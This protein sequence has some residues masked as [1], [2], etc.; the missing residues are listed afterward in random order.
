[1][2]TYKNCFELVKEVRQGI[3]EYDDALASGDVGEGVLER[4]G[5][6]VHAGVAVAGLL[7]VGQGARAV[8]RARPQRDLVKFYDGFLLVHVG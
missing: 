5:H 8:A 6:A 7:Q 2:P 4:R 3:N 1:M